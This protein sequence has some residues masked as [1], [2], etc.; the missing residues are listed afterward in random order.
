MR[1]YTTLGILAAGMTLA[2]CNESLVPDY[3][4]PTGFRHDVSALQ[5]EMT[6]AINETRVNIVFFNEAMEGFARTSAYFT[7]SEDRFVTELTG[8][9]PLD[10]DNFGTLV[11]NEEYQ[12]ISKIGTGFS[13]VLLKDL[14]DS[15]REH[16]I[17]VPRPYYRYGSANDMS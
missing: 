1:L 9:L 14:A 17:D 15:L 7:S 3:N 16:I 5:N 12:A 11:W 6:G 2:A 10:V 8:E 4:V 13:E